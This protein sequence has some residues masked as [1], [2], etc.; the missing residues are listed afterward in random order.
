MPKIKRIKHAQYQLVLVAVAS[1]EDT[2]V[3]SS[4]FLIYIVWEFVGFSNQGEVYTLQLHVHTVGELI[5]VFVNS[6]C[7]F[8]YFF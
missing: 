3:M 2:E 5:P 1:T 4:V 8:N 6:K 7:S